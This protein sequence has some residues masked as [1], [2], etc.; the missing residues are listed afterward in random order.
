MSGGHDHH[1]DVRHENRRRL[2]VVLGLALGLMIFEAVGGWLTGSLA[3]LA[4]AGHML[5]DVADLALAVVAMKFAERP[6]TPER[7]YG[8]HRVEILAALTNGVVLVGI[9]LFILAE[10]F[11]RLR[12]PPEV[13]AGTMVAIASTALV[14]NVASVFLLKKGSGESLNVR[15]AYLEVLSDMVASVGVILAGVIIW[16]TGWRYADPIVSA[17][18]GLFI[19]PRTWGL[20][21]EA[22]GVLL[23]GT[24]ANVNLEAVRTAIAA[25]QGV[26]SVHDLHVWTL[27]TGMNALSAHAVLCAG[28]GHADVLEGVRRCVQSEFKIA[29]VTLQVEE[30]GCGDAAN[31][32]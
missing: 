24:P 9:S 1:H 6:A 12:H 19:L 30:A 3:L 11:E 31:H 32:V 21:K 16:A 26:E 14:V 8:Y 13:A 2:T 28:A 29:H 25:T 27:T 23:E 7:T 4:D 5:T 10:A 18:I 15:G 22:V 20:L 17:G